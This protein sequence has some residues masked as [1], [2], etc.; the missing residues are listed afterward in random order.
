MDNTSL[1][2]YLVRNKEGKWFRAKG[3]TG[4]GDTWTDDI[5]KARVYAKVG[6]ARATVSFFANRWPE[7]GV[8]DIVKFVA[9]E[10]EV[11]D[12]ATRVESRRQAKLRKEQEYE[13]REAKRNLEEAQRKFEAATKNLAAAKSKAKKA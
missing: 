5:K 13:A 7:Y 3:F 11:L 1:D 4:Y 9:M 12:E 2:L 6:P 10:R 8:P